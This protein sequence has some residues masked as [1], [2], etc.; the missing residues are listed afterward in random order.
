MPDF[1]MSQ[2]HIDA[3]RNSTDDFNLFH[4]KNRWHKIADNPFNGPVALGFQLGCFVEDQFGQMATPPSAA[5]PSDI[6]QAEL[7]FSQYEL[8]FAGSV[9]VGDSLA[10]GA[11]ANQD[12]T[13]V[14]V[15]DDRRSSAI[16]LCV[17]NYARC[18]AVQYGYTGVSGTQVDSDNLAHCLS[19]VSLALS[20][21]CSI[22][23]SCIW[24]R[25][26]LIQPLFSHSGEG[27]DDDYD[28]LL[29]ITIAGRTRRPFR[30]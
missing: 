19:P 28:P 4:D 5:T 9:G 24:G 2:M 27:R 10:L 1:I 22:A 23:L 12:L 13:V 17:L 7:R 26:G 14:G 6:N 11:L 18:V 21:P 29:T 8:T 25:S 16:A 15:A 3:A 20:A 30:V